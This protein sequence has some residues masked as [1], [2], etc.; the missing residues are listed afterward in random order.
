MVAGNGSPVL[1]SPGDSVR[2]IAAKETKSRAPV[3]AADRRRASAS[4]QVTTSHGATIHPT[5]IIFAPPQAIEVDGILD[6][7]GL[8]RM[9]QRLNGL[10]GAGPALAEAQRRCNAVRD[11]RDG[12]LVELA[13]GTTEHWDASLIFTAFSEAAE[14]GYAFALAEAEGAGGARQRA[15]A[16]SDAQARRRWE[17]AE[18]GTE[19]FMTAV[20]QL[21]GRWPKSSAP[22][23]ARRI[24]ADLDVQ[25]FHQSHDT[26][27]RMVRR[28]RVE[29]RNAAVSRPE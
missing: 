13:A 3:P 28:L 7:P 12:L 10:Q 23:V 14:F 6:C 21:M 4:V 27:A 15:Q 18:A 2:V 9:T 29:A 16:A 24:D 22:E 17:Q 8:E 11:R 25:G 20:L 5:Q 26:I 19:A 1:L